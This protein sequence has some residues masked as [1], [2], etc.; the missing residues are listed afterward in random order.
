MAMF[1]VG[2]GRALFH[3]PLQQQRVCACEKFNRREI[4]PDGRRPTALSQPRKLAKL[5][6]LLELLKL[7]VGA[8]EGCDLLILKNNV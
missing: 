1:S 5:L 7:T 2:F 3:T 4:C 8:A 6:E